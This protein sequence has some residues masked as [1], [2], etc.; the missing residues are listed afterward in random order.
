MR[1]ALMHWLAVLLLCAAP[2]EGQ[3]REGTPDSVNLV[4]ARARGNVRQFE[5]LPWA[6]DSFARARAEKKFV[7]VDGTSKRVA[8]ECAARSPSG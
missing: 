5:W 6:T 3:V 7:L 1:R 8:G 2:V 4:K